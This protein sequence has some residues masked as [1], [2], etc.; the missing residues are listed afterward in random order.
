MLEMLII[1]RQ[2]DGA[3]GFKRRYCLHGCI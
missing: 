3:H 1:P 2:S